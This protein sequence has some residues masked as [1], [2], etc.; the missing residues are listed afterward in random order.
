MRGGANKATRPDDKRL[1][2]GGRKV[3][4]PGRI[5][6]VLLAKAKATGEL[7]DLYVERLL[8]ADLGGKM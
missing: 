6:P 7:F 4:M 2:P 8:L 1:R 5:C 3:R